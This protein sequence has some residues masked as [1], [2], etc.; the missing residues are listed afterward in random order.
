MIPKNKQ[1]QTTMV[2]VQLVKLLST[3]VADQISYTKV[4]CI[5]VASGFE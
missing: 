4:C 1:G 2:H 5:D 3:L